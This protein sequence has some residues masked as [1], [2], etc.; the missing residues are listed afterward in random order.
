[1]WLIWAGSIWLVWYAVR[2]W[3]TARPQRRRT[4]ALFM[5]LAIIWLV[6]L[7]VWVIVPLIASWVGET[8]LLRK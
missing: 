1:M 5:L 6:M 3:R 4:K 7:A 2:Q 8:V